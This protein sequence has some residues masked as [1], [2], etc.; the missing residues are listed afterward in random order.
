MVHDDVTASS[1]RIPIS[2][3]VEPQLDLVDRRWQQPAER[4]AKHHRRVRGAAVDLFRID[5]RLDRGALRRRV[6]AGAEVRPGSGA[7]RSR[8]RQDDGGDVGRS[9]RAIAGRERRPSRSVAADRRLGAR[10]PEISISA[11]DCLPV[12][13]VSSPCRSMRRCSRTVRA[14]GFA[15]CAWWMT[16][17]ARCRISSS[18]RASRS[19][20]I[21][22]SSRWPAPGLAADRIARSASIGCDCRS[23]SCPHRAW[24]SRPRPAC[25]RDRITV[26]VEHEPDRRQRD[27]WFETLV[28]S[29][30]SHADQE[31]PAPA[32]TM[33]L[34]QLDVRDLLIT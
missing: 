26:G 18:V 13:P 4:R 8:H 2:P 16:R 6:A 17:D 27:P 1:L 30:W 7:A 12:P 25:S 29:N 10:R 24:C 31:S 32:L 33:A 5:R 19:Q 22:R 34:R 11:A 28:T 23:S 9:T 20:S 14:A 15:T 3:P 21:S